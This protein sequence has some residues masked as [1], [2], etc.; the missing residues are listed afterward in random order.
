M[1]ASIRQV[2]GAKLKMRGSDFSHF[3]STDVTA[4][5][6]YFKTQFCDRIVEV[7]SSPIEIIAKDTSRYREKGQF[8]NGVKFPQ[9]AEVIVVESL[10][11]GRPQFVIAVNESHA[12]YSR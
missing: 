5:S 12:C 11:H 8:S 6:K 10:V 1:I 2:F 3:A 4:V 7:L 9:H